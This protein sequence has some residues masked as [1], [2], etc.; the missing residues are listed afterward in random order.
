MKLIAKSEKITIIKPNHSCIS[1]QSHWF[2][3]NLIA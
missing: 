2:G 3:I 1:Y